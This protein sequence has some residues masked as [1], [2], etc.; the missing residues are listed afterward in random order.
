[1]PKLESFFSSFASR[2]DLVAIN[3][4]DAISWLAG[5]GADREILA[6]VEIVLAEALNNLVEHAYGYREDG[7]IEMMLG[8]DGKSLTIELRDSGCKFPG[9]PQRKTMHGDAVKLED[10][11]EGGFGWFMIHTLTDNIEYGYVS[12]QN[13][14]RF[15]ID[16][17]S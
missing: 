12:G 9:I 4:K 1:M 7:L 8:L 10:L 17:V 11:P 14:L 3:T 16:S 13:I 5:L 6:S 2:Q 15:S